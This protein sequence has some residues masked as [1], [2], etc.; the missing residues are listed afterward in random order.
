MDR[1]GAL[2]SPSDVIQWV[3]R[4]G[5][6]PVSQAVAVYVESEDV[7][8][9]SVVGDLIIVGGSDRDRVVADR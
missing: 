1:A 5:V 3:A 6:E 4:A 7:C 9:T 2:A 8:C